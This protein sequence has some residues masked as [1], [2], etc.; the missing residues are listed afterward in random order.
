MMLL[1]LLG[2]LLQAVEAKLVI[3]VAHFGGPEPERRYQ[4]A[5]K[6]GVAP[7]GGD[8]AVRVR[9]P[10]SPIP[11]N[12]EVN[13]FVDSEWDAIAN[14]DALPSCSKEGRSMPRTTETLQVDEDGE[15]SAWL[16]GS[17]RSMHHPYIAYFAL[18]SCDDSFGDVAR[19]TQFQFRALQFDT[20]Q[21][22]FELRWMFDISTAVLVIQV[23]YGIY[24]AFRTYL[25]CRR[26][27]A[28]HPVLMVLAGAIGVQCMAEGINCFHMLVYS[29]DGR[30][31]KPV[32]IMSE[33]MLMLAQVL[34]SGIFLVIGIGYTLMPWKDDDLESVAVLICCIFAVHSM[35][36][37][38][39][40][41]EEEQHDKHHHNEGFLGYAIV[42]IRLA[43]YFFFVRGAR[44]TK[45]ACGLQ[46]QAFLDKFLIVGSAYFLAYPG[47]FIAVHLLPNHY[48]H[49][50]WQTGSMIIQC[51]AIVGLSHLFFNRGEYFK[52]SSVSASMLAGGPHTGTPKGD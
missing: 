20:S 36:V 12:V 11:G 13:I 9:M 27:G 24:F 37:S 29:L 49:P 44:K 7:G 25:F 15:W 40:H 5:A 18:T 23:A 26:L 35:L 8:Y 3:D 51:A 47:L 22:S 45:Q 41:V 42:A 17:L 10:D 30:G 34:V 21:F 39:G 52:L 4:F 33:V 31:M 19:R 28:F 43:I 16:N 46:I 6:F 38:L 32:E 14:N 1:L 50:V 48:H 2:T